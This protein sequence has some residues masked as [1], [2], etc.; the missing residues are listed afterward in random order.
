MLAVS[1]GGHKEGGVGETK[2][3]VRGKRSRQR[4]SGEQVEGLWFILWGFE[5]EINLCLGG[6]EAPWS[7][8]V[9]QIDLDKLMCSLE[10]KPEEKLGAWRRMRVK[11]RQTDDREEKWWERMRRRLKWWWH[12]RQNIIAKHKSSSSKVWVL[13]YNRKLRKSVVTKLFFF[14][15]RKIENSSCCVRRCKKH[16]LV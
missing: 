4:R 11:G 16:D 5:H 9:P 3:D 7:H 10:R 12:F 8:C 2:W 15:K 6:S 14:T 1:R 13:G